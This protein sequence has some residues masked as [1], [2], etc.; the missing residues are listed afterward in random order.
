MLKPIRGPT[1]IPIPMGRGSTFKKLNRDIKV[2]KAANTP[3]RLMINRVRCCSCR[4]SE[5]TAFKI[6]AQATP[7]GK[8]QCTMVLLKGAAMATPIKLSA[9]TNNESCQSEGCQAGS[10]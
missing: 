2:I 5:E 7:E 3:E 8:N 10:M 9:I 4:F 6:V 1:M